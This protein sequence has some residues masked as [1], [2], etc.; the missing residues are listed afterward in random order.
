VYEAPRAVLTRIF[1]RAP[2]EFDT[3]REQSTCS[4]AGGLLPQTMPGVAREIAKTRLDEH[5]RNGGGRVI[6]ACA[7]SLR[8]FRKQHAKVDDFVTL[9]ARAS[10]R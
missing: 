9:I 6:T 4:G 2:G 3:R 10:Q 5:E 1:G 8:T 7:S